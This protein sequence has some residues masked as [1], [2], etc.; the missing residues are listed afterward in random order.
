MRFGADDPA[1]LTAHQR[2]S[3]LAAILARGILRC[4]NSFPVTPES[5]QSNPELPNNREKSSQN[6]L[7][8]VST[9]RPDGQ[10]QP[11]TKR[12]D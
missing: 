9:S 7:E 12:E 2:L 6:G 10:C 4:R 11:E 3:E 5:G 8:F 1:Q